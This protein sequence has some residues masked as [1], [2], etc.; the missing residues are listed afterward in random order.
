MPEVPDVRAIVEQIE[1]RIKQI[2]AEL[3]R[4][5]R[6]SDEL[7]RLRDA[8]GRLEGAGDVGIPSRAARREQGQGARGAEAR[9]D[10]RIGA[11]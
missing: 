2:E 1:A 9:T 3:A 5:E 11:L 8:L 10:D 4:R 6:L 7:D